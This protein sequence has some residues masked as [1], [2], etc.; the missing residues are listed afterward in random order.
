MAS[1][2][3][4][5][6]TKGR[7]KILVDGNTYNLV[8]KKEYTNIHFNHM[9]TVL[10]DPCGKEQ[11]G[12]LRK[13]DRKHKR[14]RGNGTYYQIAEI[15][16]QENL[17]ETIQQIFGQIDPFKISQ[18]EFKKSEHFTQYKFFLLEQ[19]TGYRH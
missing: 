5:I 15:D 7:P 11:S 10:V 4:I 12:R 14:K 6:R 2:G 18:K 3:N 16:Q 17:E 19:L 13:Y 1:F 8:L 9:E